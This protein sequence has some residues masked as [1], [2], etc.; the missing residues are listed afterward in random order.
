MKRILSKKILFSVIIISLV[1]ISVIILISRSRSDSTKPE[2]SSALA[3]KIDLIQS[4][5]ETGSITTEMKIKYGFEK[6]GYVSKIH[7]AIGDIVYPNSIMAELNNSRETQELLQAEAGLNSNLAA[8]ELKISGVSQET[9]DEALARIAKV[10]ASL[11]GTKAEIDKIINDNNTRVEAA[12]KSLATAE[13]NLRNNQSGDNVVSKV[14]ADA[15]Q[16]ALSTL[17]SAVIGLRDRLLDADNILG[18]DNKQ[19]NDA[20]ENSLGVTNQNALL[21]AEFNY[22]ITKT[23]VNRAESTLLAIKSAEDTSAIDTALETFENAFDDMISLLGQVSTVLGASL[24]IGSLTQTEL[25]TKKTTIL[26]SAGTANTAKLTITTNI[27]NIDKAKNSV[28]LLTITRDKAKQELY[29]AE[30]S[31]RTS[32]S[33]ADANVAIKQAELNEIRASYDKLIAPPRNVDLAGLRAEVSRTRAIL[34]TAQRELNRTIIR[35]TATGTVSNLNIEVGETVNA[36]TP[37]ITTISDRFNIK[38][39]ISESEIAK[40]HLS[41]KA[42]ITLDAFGD[43]VL[44]EGNVEKI[45]PAETEIS[46]VVHYKTTIILGELGDYTEL[47][48]PGMTA[49]VKIITAMKPGVIVIPERAVL[50]EEGKKNIRILTPGGKELFSLRH[51]ITGIKGDDGKIEV[52]SGLQVGEEVITFLKYPK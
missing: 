15:Y 39:D 37:I 46:G 6:S 3:E 5:E 20:F 7:V 29:S 24:P 49:N 44:F 16:N 27:Q 52:V 12:E 22:P 38:V 4:V 23:S 19:A 13:E 33:I 1:I 48:R 47:V 26:T 31:A 14:T 11:L 34:T 50:E 36:N 43:D 17:Q 40:I 42:K 32:L 51:V 41:D 9:R 35:A 21:I 10:E 30:I 28:N 45:E 8:L 25:N 18:I 2:Y